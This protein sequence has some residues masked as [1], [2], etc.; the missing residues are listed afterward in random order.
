MGDRLSD[1]VAIRGRFHRSINL[2]R[3][4]Q[5]GADLSEYVV[6]PTVRELARRI[7]DELEHPVGA[8]AWSIT[9]PYGSGKSAFGLFLA[10]LLAGE[11][12][13]HP[14][15][16]VL[17]KGRKVLR[18]RF[19]PILVIAE[20]APLAQTILKG[21]SEALKP[22]AP[23]LSRRCGDAL[24]D[25]H[26]TG[27]QLADLAIEA[28]ES[29]HERDFAGLF[30]VIDELGKYLEHAAA[31]QSHGDVF[32]LQQLAEGATRSKAPF[33]IA[34]IL[35]S[36]FAD[37]LP[38]EQEIRR[39]EW[40]KVQGRY[41]DVAFQLPTEQLL[42]L[43]GRAIQQKAPSTLASQWRAITDEVVASGFMAEARRRLPL[44]ELL[45]DCAP[46]HPIASLLL[47]PLFRSKV[48]QNER[49]LFAFLTG[50]EPFGFQEFLKKT[51]W[52]SDTAPVYRASDLFDYVANALGLA[53][54]TGEHA[55]KWSLIDHAL[56]RIPRDAPEV[57]RA[58]VK[59]IGLLSIYGPSVGLPASLEAVRAAVG[60]DG[61]EDA[62]RLLEDKSIVVFRRHVGGYALWE[63][64]DVDLE[65]AFDEARRHISA[66][67]LQARLKS[68]LNL[69]PTIARAQ[70]IESGTL[71]LFDVDIV[72]NEMS[73]LETALLQQPGGV[74]G[75]ILFVV[76]SGPRTTAEA[77][78]AAKELTKSLGDDLLLVAVPRSIGGLEDALR[79]LECW[80]W[81]AQNLPELQGDPVARHEAQARV[82]VARTHFERIAGRSFGLPGYQFD[83]GLS[84]WIHNGDEK[85]IGSPIAFQRLLS[86]LCARAFNKAPR[87]HNEL[88]N[89]QTL[90]SAAA[91]ARRNLL[92]RM[93]SNPATPRLGI[94]GNPPEASMYESLLRATG[95]HRSRSKALSL[96][97]PSG[98]W[99]AVWDAIERFL[100]ES[101][102][103]RRSLLSLFAMLKGRPYG[104]REGSIPVILTAVLA[105]TWA[106]TALYEEGVFVP[107]LRIEVLERLVRRPE[108]FELQS[109][110]LDRHQLQ[111]LKALE[112]I[113]GDVDGSGLLPVVKELVLFAARLSPYAR[114]TSRMGA[115]EAIAA[116][117]ALLRAGD[118]RKLLFEDLPAATGVVIDGR[119]GAAAFAR[120]LQQALRS[121]SRAYPDLLDELERQTRHVFALSGN[122][123]EARQQLQRRALPIE[124]FA[125]EQRL[126]LFVREVSRLA[127]DK[128]WRETV[129]R[130]VNGGMPP[131]HWRDGDVAAFQ[132]RLQEVAS[133]FRRLEE[134]VAERGISGVSRVL[135]L[136]VL[137]G[138]YQ[139]MRVV[140]PINA[141]VESRSLLL[142]DRIREVIQQDASGTRTEAE[143]FAALATVVRELLASQ[144]EVSPNV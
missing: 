60:L 73:T 6:T 49:S 115:K 72:S 96:G 88:I 46:L 70:Y 21:F 90:S 124:E 110:R 93:L 2:T 144:A 33:V 61:V 119:D 32:L 71:R 126:R 55:R 18:K 37:Y 80:Q 116:R 16:N 75:K 86:H 81:V 102:G 95:I 48:A 3:D 12:S 54:F 19:L 134:L 27:A 14:E 77:V 64:S 1:L 107:E 104:L 112:G 50:E 103:S 129:G 26:F 4:W 44:G 87:L 109:H 29:V 137:E 9:G 66:Q 130:V 117:D 45:Y 65:A 121:M 28:A 30:L 140:L 105:A 139:E 7:V 67:T 38:V 89:R 82:A 136:G 78:R 128:D 123:Q 83:P 15:S 125:V 94:E 101:R 132:V 108:T 22:V 58:V 35:H 100:H 51:E 36:S 57:S 84:L 127:P 5:R 53:A 8:R 17:R 10:D 79:D 111:A 68:S 113:I 141:D 91:A 40:Q 31:D 98:E 135:R 41:Q 106:E 62:I 56:S 11:A 13:S 85:A 25:R 92:A 34:T 138:A 143:V 120:G 47:W 114:S 122:A 42:A 24:K 76:G 142:A 63:G 133:E 118:P 74:D 20:R 99:R 43:V 131:T 69:R 39:A 97:R 59:T 23:G 52:K